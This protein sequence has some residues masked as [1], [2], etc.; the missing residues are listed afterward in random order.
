MPP[1]YTL[2]PSGNN[3]ERDQ[4]RKCGTFSPLLRLPYGSRVNPYA[5]AVV[6]GIL[7]Q[8]L[9]LLAY[10]R[11]FERPVCIDA[12][13]IQIKDGGE[14]WTL[15]KAREMVSRTK[16]YY[17]RD[18]SLN[19]GWNNVR[20]IIEA[21]VYDTDACAAFLPK[22]HWTEAVHSLEWSDHPFDEEYLFRVPL[23]AV[24]DLRRLRT[25]PTQ[26]EWDSKYSSSLRW[27]VITVA[28][29]LQLHGL[30]P[31]IEQHNGYWS[32][33]DYQLPPGT[34][35]TAYH[36]SLASEE[37]TKK[38][39]AEVG[40]E[41]GDERVPRTVS[42]LRRAIEA[43]HA[44]NIQARSDNGG[45]TIHEMLNENWDTF[46]LVRVD[47]VR[48]LRGY[49]AQSWEWANRSWILSGTG[50]QDNE[51]SQGLFRRL[52]ETLV[53]NNQ[54]VM[55]ISQVRQLAQSAG[56]NQT[57]ESN[58]VLEKI[59]NNAGWD[60][61]YTF[62]G[63][64]NQEFIKTIVWP[65]MQVAPRAHMRGFVN[66]LAGRVEDIV[67]VSGEMHLERKAGLMRFT[68]SAAR[69]EYMQIGL[70]AMRAPEKYWRIASRVES[71]M[72][73]KCGGRMFMAAHIRRGDFIRF[74]WAPDENLETHVGQVRE[75]L[76][77]GTRILS[78]IKKEYSEKSNLTHMDMEVAQYDLPR[79]DDPFY[80][81]T[82]EHSPHG[83][84]TIHRLGGVLIDDLLTPE[85]R[86]T[87]GWEMLYSDLIALVE[88]IVMSRASY[89]NAHAMSSLAGGVVN[90]RAA[91][92][93]DS[94][95]ALLD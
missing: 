3:N 41:Q 95:T 10:H 17:A 38:E 28:E 55:E 53:E 33:A 75:K 2:L 45:S 36:E 15:E 39:A 94:R 35:V 79:D 56:Y 22:V 68:S 84:D 57:L 91:R 12:N 52:N 27:P 7:L 31:Q 73:V 48:V 60:F 67:L 20:Y 47:D 25:G 87:C 86:A 49:H 23:E 90:L 88:Q 42:G 72:R 71:H 4:P 74:G 59:I 77:A 8:L 24:L 5:L 62:E 14:E 29:Y 26:D 69:D 1:A 43:V 92:G 18:Y 21:S 19:L 80:V 6:F 89:W 85:D 50:A 54:V 76:R 83:I 34:N 40:S 51:R 64:L 30:D 44:Y 66:D 82:D 11:V 37:G 16:G 78:D 65:M 81:A 58:D 46:P 9:L 70:Y 32:R 13:E 63:R 93:A 61:V